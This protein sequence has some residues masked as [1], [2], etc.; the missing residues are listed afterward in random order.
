MLA[1]PKGTPSDIIK[2]LNGAMDQI[3]KQPELVKRLGELGFYVE[4]ALTPETTAEFV[5]SQRDAWGDQQP[6]SDHRQ[7]RRRNQGTVQRGL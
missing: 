5:R 6:Q 1:A 4:G 2:R 7:A 3:L